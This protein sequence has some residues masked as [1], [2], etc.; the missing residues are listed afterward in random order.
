VQPLRLVL[1]IVC[2]LAL[3]SGAQA[4]TVSVDGVPTYATLGYVTGTVT[5]V[6]PAT[7]HVAVYIHIEGSGWWTKPTTVTPTVPIDPAGQF[8][9]NVGTGGAGSLDPYATIF[10]A[11]LL[12]VATSPPIAL[13]AG[14]IPATLSPLAIDCHERH[15]RTV[16]FAGRTWGVKSAP[17]PVGPGP[18]PFSARTEDVFVDAAGLHLRIDFHDS[19]WWSTEVILLET[20]GYGT[21]SVQTDSELDDLDRDVTLGM[22]T[23]DSYGDEETVPGDPFREIDFE[24]GRWGNAADPT[25]AHMVV[26]PYTNPENLRR[27]TIPDLAADARLTRFFTWLPGQIEFVALSGHHDPTS[28]PGAAVIDE[29]LYVDAPPQRHVPTEG[30]E[31]FAINLWLALGATQPASGQPVE[32]LITD[33]SFVPEPGSPLLLGSGLLA[34]I[35]I[36]RRSPRTRPR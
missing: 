3:T 34:L 29:W 1:A 20:L 7:H 32:V 8:S 4:Q 24:D 10:C 31:T 36:A 23:W 33:F 17:L 13:G 15:G 35:G 22:F 9:A 21:Y 28:Y 2:A 14:R 26:Q 12:P 5:G 6:E 19:Q 11:A 25:N 27:Y 16:S 30:R 18:N